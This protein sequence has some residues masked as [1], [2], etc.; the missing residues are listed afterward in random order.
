VERQTQQRDREELQ[1]K[2]ER[3]TVKKK[4]ETQKRSER[5]SKDREI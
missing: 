5:D 4:I 1:R 2:T 3:G